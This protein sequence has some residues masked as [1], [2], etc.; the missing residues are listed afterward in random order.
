M[1]I[2]SR[3]LMTQIHGMLFGAFFL[4]AIFAVAVELWRTVYETEPRVLTSAC[5]SLERCYLI[6]TVLVGWAAVLTGAYV[7]YPWY[8]A[9]PPAGLASLA[10]YPQ[11][12]LKSSPTTAG[13]HSLGMEW[14]EHIAWF[15]PIAMTMIAY[16][17]IK[18]GSSIRKHAQLRNAL[19]VFVIVALFAAGVAGYFGAEIDDH[20]P[21][22]GGGN[23]I[24]WTGGTR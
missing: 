8:R 2:S 1:E 19:L 16:V 3:G 7:V 9:I 12:L 6:A 4:L 20:A 5:R 13:W 15:A 23:A 10:Q 24:H 21:V 11:A 14:K 22:H 17:S 18:Y